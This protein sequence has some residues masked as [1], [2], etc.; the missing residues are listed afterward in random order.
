MQIDKTHVT[1]RLI[2]SLEVEPHG[3]RHFRNTIVRQPVPLGI[4][5]HPE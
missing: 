1:E 3:Y 2:A 4:T 5:L